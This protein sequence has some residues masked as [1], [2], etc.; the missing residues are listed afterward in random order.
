M[1]GADEIKDFTDRSGAQPKPFKVDDDVFYGAPRLPV[2]ATQLLVSLAKADVA[3]Q[4]AKIGDILDLI[5]LPGS[6]GRFVEKMGD[7]TNPID[8][9]QLGEIIE[10]LAEEYTGR[11]TMP[12]SS[13]STSP[14]PDG[15]SSMVGQLQEV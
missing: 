11:P 2:K 3:T 14:T 15:T 9:K 13:S 5:L 8:D 10:W 6:V 12:P 1:P 4:L 7:P